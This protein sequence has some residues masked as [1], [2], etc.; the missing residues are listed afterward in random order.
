VSERQEET[1][2]GVPAWLLAE[3]LAELGGSGD[4]GLVVG[5]GWRATIEAQRRPPGTMAIGRVRMSIEGPEAERVMEALR[6][7]AQRGGG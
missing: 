6:A 3:Y 5:H 1:F 4:D 2:G 7:K